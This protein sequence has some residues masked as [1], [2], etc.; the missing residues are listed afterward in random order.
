MPECYLVGQQ[1]MGNSKI[2]IMNGGNAAVGTDADETRA[3]G[4]GIGRGFS[5][6][7]RFW[8][9]RPPASAR[10]GSPVAPQPTA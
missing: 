6:A 8:R 1:D 4:S 9:A 2:M 5:T 3:L 7:A 10:W